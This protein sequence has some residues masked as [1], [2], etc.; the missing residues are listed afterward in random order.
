MA[1]TTEPFTD[2][3]FEDE[4]RRHAADHEVFMSF[5]GDSDAVAFREW[6][7]DEGAKRFGAWLAKRDD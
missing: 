5:N 3:T 2:V 4:V 1:K 7:D 6:W